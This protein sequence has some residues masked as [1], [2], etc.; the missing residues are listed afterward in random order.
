MQEGGAA[1]LE[2]RGKLKNY[3]IKEKVFSF[4][5]QA[6]SLMDFQTFFGIEALIDGHGERDTPSHHTE[7]PLINSH[8]FPY[9]H[10]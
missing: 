3:G 6:A 7:N 10:Y 1:L 8:Q 5:S 2:S 4:S 9:L